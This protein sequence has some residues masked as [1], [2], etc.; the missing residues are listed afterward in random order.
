[1]VLLITCLIFNVKLADS[2]EKCKKLL[3]TKAT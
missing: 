2:Y 1:M 3:L